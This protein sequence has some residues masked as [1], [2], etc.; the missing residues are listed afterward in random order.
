MELNVVTPFKG[1]H[2]NSHKNHNPDCDILEGF[3]DDDSLITYGIYISK[4]QER[5]KSF[6]NIIEAKTIVA[7]QQS[8]VILGSGLQ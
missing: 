3:L 6:A 4:D 1:T 7:N 2:F 5:V 8:V